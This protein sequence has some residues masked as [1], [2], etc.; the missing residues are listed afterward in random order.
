MDAWET[1][2][3]K[4][5]A[6][7]L[8]ALRKIHKLRPGPAKKRAIASLHDMI[9]YGIMDRHQKHWHKIDGVWYCDTVRTRRLRTRGSSKRA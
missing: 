8:R 3:K 5:R 9:Y 1:A 2:V 7:I 4:R 6:G